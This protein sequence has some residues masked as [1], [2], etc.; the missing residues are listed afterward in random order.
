MTQNKSVDWDV[1]SG[2]ESSW[3]QKGVSA[4]SCPSWPLAG[5]QRSGRQQGRRLNL[6]GGLTFLSV[7]PEPSP[8]FAVFS[9]SLAKRK[10]SSASPPG[11]LPLLRDCFWHG[12]FLTNFLCVPWPLRSSC[13]TLP[14]TLCAIWCFGVFVLVSCKLL[15]SSCFQMRFNSSFEG[16]TK[17]R[18]SCGYF[19]P[20]CEVVSGLWNALFLNM[21]SP[22]LL[23]GLWQDVWGIETVWV[24]SGPR[25]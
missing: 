16:G 8:L 11:L 4:L 13:L 18:G 17:C 14:G 15:P 9:F 20:P 22:G 21:Q 25:E 5:F 24:P 23:K 2:L 12:L 19:P 6:S 10:A 3:E 1:A 7:G